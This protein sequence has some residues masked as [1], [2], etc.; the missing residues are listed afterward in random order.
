MVIEKVLA[1]WDS[2]LAVYTLALIFIVGCMLFIVILPAALLNT[3]RN[4]TVLEKIKRSMRVC[5]A[6]FDA[7]VLG[8]IDSKSKKEK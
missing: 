4:Y 6:V 5:F 2:V 1:Y 8:L 7:D 3:S